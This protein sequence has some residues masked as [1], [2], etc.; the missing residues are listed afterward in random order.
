MNNF[1]ELYDVNLKELFE[2]IKKKISYIDYL[3]SIII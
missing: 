1:N 3:L 2:V